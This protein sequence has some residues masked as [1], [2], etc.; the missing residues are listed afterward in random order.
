MWLLSYKP[1]LENIREDKPYQSYW[2]SVGVYSYRR[3]GDPN[4]DTLFLQYVYDFEICVS[5]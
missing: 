5:Q 1:Y 3:S 4:F 2:I